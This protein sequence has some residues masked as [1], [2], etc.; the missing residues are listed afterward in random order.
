MPSWVHFR[1]SPYWSMTIPWTN[2]TSECTH[3]RRVCAQRV[4]TVPCPLQIS[5]AFR[6]IC[7]RHIRA[8]SDQSY[9]VRRLQPFENE[10]IT[11]EMRVQVTFEAYKVSLSAIFT[12][13]LHTLRYPAL[14]SPSC[15]SQSLP[16]PRPRPHPRHSSPPFR[17]LSRIHRRRDM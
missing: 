17:I 9:C 16:S 4:L 2:G 1:S 12:P 11:G 7:D 3:R 13:F 6:C 8:I 14:V 5:S 10:T 15:P